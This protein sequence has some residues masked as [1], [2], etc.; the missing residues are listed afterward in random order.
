M[1]HTELVALI[2]GGVPSI[3]GT[4]AELG[5][6]GGNFTGALRELLGREGL[7]YA[8]DRDARAI[9]QQRKR[10]VG[11]TLG[12]KVSPLVADFTQPIAMPPLDGVLMCNALHFVRDQVGVL[13]RIYS[14]LRPGGRLLLVEYDFRMPRPWVPVPVSA[15][16]FGLLATKAGFT[17]PTI[18]GKRRSP[19]SGNEM[20]AAV[21]LRPTSQ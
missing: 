17:P 18:V 21:A 1:E 13:A 4:W 20:Y 3:G 6:G 8:I 2:R 11:A 10:W 14:Y 5:A 9:E 19:S 7:I 12:A 15:E 16:K